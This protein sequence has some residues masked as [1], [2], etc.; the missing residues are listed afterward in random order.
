MY[1]CNGN[2]VQ[3]TDFRSRIGQGDFYRFLSLQTRERDSEN[4][5]VLSRHIF[6][7]IE[8]KDAENMAIFIF[9]S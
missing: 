5:I 2:N 9:L 8:L 6:E 4:E 7:K 1:V 3:C